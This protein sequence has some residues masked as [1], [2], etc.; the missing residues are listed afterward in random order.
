MLF[1]RDK[2]EE[3]PAVSMYYYQRQQAMKVLQRE[4]YQ[5]KGST[6]ETTIPSGG[7]SYV[8][9]NLSRNAF[10]GVSIPN[11]HKSMESMRTSS[12]PRLSQGKRISSFLENIPNQ[13]SRMSTVGPLLQ[14]AAQ[15][16]R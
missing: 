12:L 6:A 3:D 14:G 4:S 16:D 13:Q 1:C 10:S 9:S 11:E 15:T 7:T 2:D 5:K 8:L